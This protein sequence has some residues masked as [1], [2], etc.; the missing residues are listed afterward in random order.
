MSEATSSVPPLACTETNLFLGLG[1]KFQV[2]VFESPLYG[3]S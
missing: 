1:L 2:Q 3:P